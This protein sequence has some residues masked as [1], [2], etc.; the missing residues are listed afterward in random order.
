MEAGL[1]AAEMGEKAVKYGKRIR[2]GATGKHLHR[3]ADKRQNKIK[4]G[5]YI[6]AAMGH[7]EKDVR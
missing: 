3:K 4:T 1:G 2:F 7:R 5:R 6:G